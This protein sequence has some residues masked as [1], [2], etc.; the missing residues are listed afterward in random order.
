MTVSLFSALI[1]GGVGVILA[2]YAFGQSSIFSDRLQLHLLAARA[3]VLGSCSSAGADLVDD[4][5]ACTAAPIQAAEPLRVYSSDPS[6]LSIYF[7]L[8]VRRLLAALVHDILSH[9]P[10]PLN[11]ILFCPLIRAF[12]LMTVKV[13]MREDTEYARFA[14]ASHRFYTASIASLSVDSVGG[15]GRTAILQVR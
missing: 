1:R 13:N 3:C 6:D 9:V 10:S 7:D 12:Q 15:A 14:D 4:W 5:Q 8:P 11:A 2:L